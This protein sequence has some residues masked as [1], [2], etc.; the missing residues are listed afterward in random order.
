MKIGII[1]AA[2]AAVVMAPSA[3]VAQE[4][5]VGGS[6]GTTMQ[7]DSSNSGTTGAFN[8]GN[9]APAVPNGTAIAAGTPYGWETEFD[10]GYAVSGEA[11]LF[12]GSG[13]RSGV[14]IVHSQAD[15]DS[16]SG[17]N[18]A[19]GAIQLDGV[20]AA[21][22]TGSAT[23]LGA[24]VG[25]VVADGRGEIQNTSLFLNAYYDFNR[26]GA[27]QPYVGAGIGL[28]SADVTYNPS[29]VGI[30]DGDDTVFAWQLKAGLTY[31]VSDRW[32]V[33]GEYAY[34]QSDDIELQ[35]QLFSGSLEIENQQNVFSIGARMKLG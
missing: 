24:S 26:D 14:E 6:I 25:A 10:S 16:H 1:A 29:G 33:Y 11:G 27:W 21:V 7:S 28:T 17:V 32:S 12:Y 13:F 22:V 23:Q 19:G 2:A 9:G 3:A 15:V 18:L 30:I 31:E 34:R 8:T 5:Y 20:D 35:N 4:W